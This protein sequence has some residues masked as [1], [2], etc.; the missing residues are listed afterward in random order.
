MTRLY[1][2]RLNGFEGRGA[3]KIRVVDVVPTGLTVAGATD[4]DV[5]ILRA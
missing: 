1:Q 5:R 2:E 4:E 3:F